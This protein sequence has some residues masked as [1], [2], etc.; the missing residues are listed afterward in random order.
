[1]FPDVLGSAPD[2]EPET[3]M[4]PNMKLVNAYRRLMRSGERL[5][6]RFVHHWRG[7]KFV[8]ARRCVIS[9]FA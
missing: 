8:V 9:G 5:P 4:R 2:P 6:I 7:R 3:L 1:V